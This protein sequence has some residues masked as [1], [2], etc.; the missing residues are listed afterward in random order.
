M[1]I[2]S[3]QDRILAQEEINLALEERN[4]ALEETLEVFSVSQDQDPKTNPVTHPLTTHAV[5]PPTAHTLKPSSEKS[6]PVAVPSFATTPE[7]IEKR[8]NEDRFEVE[9]DGKCVE[10]S[11]TVK[12]Y[13]TRLFMFQPKKSSKSASSASSPSSICTKDKKC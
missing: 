12:N 2:K 1:T 6:A 13:L 3:L 11:E 7:D 5:P 9:I 8:Q 10:L 4:L